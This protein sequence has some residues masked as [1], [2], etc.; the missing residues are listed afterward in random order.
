MS[1]GLKFLIKKN[2]IHIPA[3]E[4]VSCVTVKYCNMQ[5]VGLLNILSA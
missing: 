4:V 5:A 3:Y 2:R 1:G